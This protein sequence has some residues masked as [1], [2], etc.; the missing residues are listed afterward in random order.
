MSVADA[1]VERARRRRED[2]KMSQH[3]LARRMT[4]RMPE[5][6]YQMTVSRTESGLRPVR[7]DEAAAMADALGLAKPFNDDATAA[8]QAVEATVEARIA[9]IT[10][11]ADEQIAEMA[12]R[13]TR[14][15]ARAAQMD[16]A[17]RAVRAI[18]NREEAR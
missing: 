6:W 18:V 7:L 17:L 14:A 12:E 11:Q 2:L 16:S 4:D 3:E 5:T 13:L 1:F 9:E 15:N 10:K 8:E